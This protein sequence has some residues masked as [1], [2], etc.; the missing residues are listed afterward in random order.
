MGFWKRCH[1]IYGKESGDG[2]GWC[3]YV[4]CWSCEAGGKYSTADVKMGRKRVEEKPGRC[5][6]S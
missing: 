4:R 5:R 1:V 2:G 3:M 6:V